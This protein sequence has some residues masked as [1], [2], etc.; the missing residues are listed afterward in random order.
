[1][2]VALL[3]ALLFFSSQ[4]AFSQTYGLDLGTDELP[5]YA[6]LRTGKADPIPYFELAWSFFRLVSGLNKD[7]ARMGLPLL[8]EN[9]GM[10][11]EDAQQFLARINEALHESDL[12]V[13]L[14]SKRSCSPSRASQLQTRKKIAE[15]MA[16]SEA[17]LAQHREQ[18][19]ADV[20]GTL[21]SET[22]QQLYNW[23]DENVRPNYFSITTDYDKFVE[24]VQLDPETY[25]AITCTDQHR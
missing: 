10:S 16:A 15:A 14:E 13:I 8:K 3:A 1:M 7:E 20:L 22:N 6:K 18:L 11:E 25:R 2:R 4:I 12:E 23:I 19:V 17:K 9:I 5:S 24:E 21:S